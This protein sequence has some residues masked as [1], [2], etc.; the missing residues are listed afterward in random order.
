MIRGSPKKDSSP[1]SNTIPMWDSS[2]PTRA[3][4]S[5]PIAPDSPN[6]MPTGTGPVSG[7]PFRAGSSSSTPGFLSGASKIRP[8]SS[9]NEDRIV[10]ILETTR[11]IRGQNETIERLVSDLATSKENTNDNH[12]NTF[13]SNL[14]VLAALKET[15]D[16][17]ETRTQTLGDRFE[18][19]VTSVK[20]SN[21]FA[22]IDKKLNELST[23]SEELLSQIGETSITSNNKIISAI[24]KLTQKSTDSHKEL[25]SVVS[26]EHWL[27]KIANLTKEQTELVLA[28]IMS[29]E[30]T[31]QDFAASQNQIHGLELKIKALNSDSEHMK[32]ENSRLVA[33]LGAAQE[34]LVKQKVEL[35]QQLQ[36]A[37]NARRDAEKRLE[38]TE[39]AKMEAEKK[40]TALLS[41]SQ[42]YDKKLAET[43]KQTELELI[44]SSEAAS[45]AEK[46]LKKAL[47]SQLSLEVNIK[48]LNETINKLVL[49]E[50]DLS[51][52]L[53]LKENE[54]NNQKEFFEL[55]LTS[56]KTKLTESNQFY[57]SEIDRLKTNFAK[58]EKVSASK[59]S[60]LQSSHAKSMKEEQDKINNLLADHSARN[61]AY[62][63]KINDILLAHS[64]ELELQQEKYDNIVSTHASEIQCF[65]DKISAH[66]KELDLHNDKLS[67]ISE[68]HKKEKKSM[69][70]K[71]LAYSEE[72]QTKKDSIDTLTADF[73]KEKQKLQ[74]KL[75][76]LQSV[77]E[78]EKNELSAKV[79]DL[80]IIQSKLQQDQGE[81]LEQ[82]HSEYFKKKDELLGKVNELAAAQSKLQQI[83]EENVKSMVSTHSVE[84]SE[85]EQRIT[86]LQ[87]KLDDTSSKLE[88]LVTKHAS[89]FDMFLSDNSIKLLDAEKKVSKIELKLQQVETQKTQIEADFDAKQKELNSRIEIQLK[90]FENKL[91]NEQRE[92]ALEK[93]NLEIKHEN[94]V[95]VYTKKIADLQT[96][97]TERDTSIFEYKAKL[98]ALQV[99]LETATDSVRD[100]TKS[101]VDANSSSA[102]KIELLESQL[103]EVE[104]TAAADKVSFNRELVEAKEARTLLEFSSKEQILNYESA[105]R[106]ASIK[107]QKLESDFK[108]FDYFDRDLKGYEAKKAAAADQIVKL[109][110]QEIAIQ[111]RVT[112]LESLLTSRI[113]GLRTLESRVDAFE[114]RLAQSLLD[115]S[116]SIIGTTT[117]SILNT[118]NGKTKMSG[119]NDDNSN[120]D[121][122]NLEDYGFD[123]K[124]NIRRNVSLFTRNMNIVPKET[125]EDDM[126]TASNSINDIELLGE[127]DLEEKENG[128]V[129]SAASAILNIKKRASNKRSVSLVVR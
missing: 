5:L 126:A 109:H 44:Q 117:L 64:K 106:E 87:S 77:H 121:S 13:E 25:I 12:N 118:G 56:L 32:T 88:T 23:Q 127:S 111:T 15:N 94:D 11:E 115:K 45:T 21:N 40:L 38:Y 19:V 58:E 124:R 24:E 81:K 67:T 95:S 128:F 101:L 47:E 93:Q 37:A 16:L 75:E 84:K 46:N 29:F 53:D 48:E 125:D 30:S 7:S 92:F 60:D 80:S 59:L 76:Q 34:Q 28:K 10:S 73:A 104:Q 85:Y 79:N 119:A 20:E 43:K 50:K 110:E 108:L 103:K 105:A 27:D 69:E 98:D 123:S 42:N 100:L 65:T 31:V 55:K 70:N 82:I 66:K 90:E 51:H 96:E 2:D 99:K 122:R 33:D 83:H 78:K 8:Y 68:M 71:I 57:E 18:Y 74:E 91:K 52:T 129:G 112:A 35:Y 39:T 107:L 41:E 22:E 3:P 102:N 36:D 63:K 9:I 14:E 120:S 89:K 49:A 26:Y 62:E 6:L 61:E 113:E 116:K 72:L 86:Q 1:P 97:L 4:P 17:L 114:R 54:L